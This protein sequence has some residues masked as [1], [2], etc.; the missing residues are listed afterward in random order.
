MKKFL[1]FFAVIIVLLLTAAIALP[2]L[3]KDKI[4]AKAKEEINKNINAKVNFGD[5]DL[6]ILSSF[7]N[8]TFK[9]NNFSIVGIN[10]FDG[11]TLTYI[12]QLGLKL[13]IW[14][15]ISGSQYK[16]KSITLQKPS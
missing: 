3:F 15:V 6:T 8:L 4:I 10:D 5:F 7:P 2:F 12:D 11:D 16:I 9:L 1:K 13:S 14:D